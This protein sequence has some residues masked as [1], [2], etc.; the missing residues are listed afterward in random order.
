MIVIVALE[1]NNKYGS[2]YYYF[3]SILSRFYQE[4]GTGIKIQPVFMNGKTNYKN[5]KS[6]IENIK[7][8]Y[9]VDTDE[10]NVIYFLDEDNPELNCDQKILN[11]EIKQYCSEYKYEIV[12]FNKTIEDVLL[13]KVITKDKTNEAKKFFE[14]ELIYKV[15][16]KQLYTGAHSSHSSNVLI[17]FLC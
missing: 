8:Q 15:D 13:G 5:I 7:K 16:K 3:K 4:R 12:W 14:N 11:E 9:S 2:D 6:K 1:T 17:I 10:S